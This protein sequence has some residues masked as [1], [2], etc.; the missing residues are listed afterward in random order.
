VQPVDGICGKRHR[1][2]E[3][4]ARGR[5]DDVVV[6]GLRDA[7]EGMPRELGGDRQPIALDTY[8]ASRRALEYLHHTIAVVDVPS[9]VAINQTDPPVHGPEHSA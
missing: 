8:G 2:V 1:R 6:D 3:P 9:G 5:A 4:E 7:D